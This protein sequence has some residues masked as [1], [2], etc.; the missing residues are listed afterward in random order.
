MVRDPNDCTC[1]GATKYDAHGNPMH[2]DA[3]GGTWR[4]NDPAVK[5]AVHPWGYDPATGRNDVP[6]PAPATPAASPPEPAAP[7]AP[8]AP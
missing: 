7:P 2:P 1:P 4:S 8:P 5:C 6:P 3:K